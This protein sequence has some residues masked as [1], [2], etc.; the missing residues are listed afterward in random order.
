M[1][2]QGRVVVD[3]EVLGVVVQDIVYVVL[4][5]L[6][7]AIAVMEEKLHFEGLRQVGPELQVTST[8][9]TSSLQNH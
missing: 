8:S 9:K 1:V 2:V 4:G 7:L 5:L 3:M 6:V